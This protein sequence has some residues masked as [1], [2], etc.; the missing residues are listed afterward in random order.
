M[1]R[2]STKGATIA[3]MGTQ[4]RTFTV[5]LTVNSDPTGCKSAAGVLTCTI[6]ESL[7]AGTYH[8]TFATFDKAPV[9]GAN[10]GDAK[11]LSSA[12]NLPW[13]LVAGAV[14]KKDF[15]LDGIVK[16]LI[17]DP[18]S[19]TLGT[20]FVQAQPFTVEADDADG[21]IIAGTY[22][23]PV[24][25]GD[26]DSTH[27]S[28][29]KSTLLSSSDVVGL[30]LRRRRAVICAKLAG[31]PGER[32]RGRQCCVRSGAGSHVDYRRQRHNRHRRF[33]NRQRNVC[34]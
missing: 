6:V 10:P 1:S 17:V 26:N 5:G 13:T 3:L 9:S 30:N 31:Q 2:R 20:A 21:N 12:A 8:L 14:N 19:G 34:R 4:N 16:S 23:A 11:E 32:R 24:S 33:R 15:T 28:L 22:A 27:T 25:I 18:P 29:T 7:P